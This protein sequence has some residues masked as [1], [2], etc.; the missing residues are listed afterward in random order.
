MQENL[1]FP[2]YLNKGSKDLGP[3][4][5]VRL[6]QEGLSQFFPGTAAKIRLV[7]DGNYGD[8]TEILVIVLQDTVN[9]KLG[10]RFEELLEVD[11]NFEPATRTACWDNLQDWYVMPARPSN[12]GGACMYVGPDSPEPI[13]WD[14][15][16]DENLPSTEEIRVEG[17]A[18]SAPTSED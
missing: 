12:P 11:G 3:N 4:G 5:P 8:R 17:T 6:L 7:V 14:P 10:N 9:R 2:P 1:L 16:A 15:L 13:L 18:A